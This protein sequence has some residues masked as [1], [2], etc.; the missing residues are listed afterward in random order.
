MPSFALSIMI[1]RF[2]S[3]KGIWCWVFLFVCLFFVCGC[4]GGVFFFFGFLLLLLFFVCL[5]CFVVLFV[6]NLAPHKL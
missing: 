4:V 3:C 2:L 6:L 5:F 1:E